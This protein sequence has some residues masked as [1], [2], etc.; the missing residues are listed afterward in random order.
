MGIILIRGEEKWTEEKV[1]TKRG[2]LGTLSSIDFKIGF[3]S[4]F[5]SITFLVLGITRRSYN[6]NGY[7]LNG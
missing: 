5:L 1:K 6:V 2:K 4:L 3:V 7:P